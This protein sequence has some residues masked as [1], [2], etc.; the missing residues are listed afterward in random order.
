MPQDAL[1][2]PTSAEQLDRLRNKVAPDE[3]GSSLSLIKQA[4]DR[5]LAQSTGV[6]PLISWLAAYGSADPRN[7]LGAAAQAMTQAVGQQAASKQKLDLDVL[8]LDMA[9]AEKREAIAATA[10]KARLDR[11]AKAQDKTAEYVAV[12]DVD[13]K[14]T[15]IDKNS[16]SG[17]TAIEAI[18]SRGGTVLGIGTQ[19][20][21]RDPLTEKKLQLEI[22]ALENK[23]NELNL[24]E[25]T[26]ESFLNALPE[27]LQSTVKAIAEG[28][29]NPN[30]LS[31][32]NDYRN[33]ILAAVTQYDPNFDARDVLSR[34]RTEVD[35]SVGKPSQSI[36]AAN[37]LLGHLTTLDSK[38]DNLDN[39]QISGY[40]TVANW[41]SKNSGNPQ[42]TSFLVARKAVVNELERVFKGTGG[43]LSEIRDWESAISSAGSTAQLKDAV[44]TAADLMESRTEA[45]SDN[46]ERIMGKR[47]QFI[48]PKGI[49]ALE[50]IKG[51]T[52][53]MVD[54][55][56]TIL[57]VPLSLVESAKKDGLTE[58]EQ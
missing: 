2:A 4:K 50:K 37:T 54:P 12:T 1:S 18:L 29:L 26:G 40:N 23:G 11:D 58:R 33:H 38:I 7:K 43:S 9:A 51:Q 19:K 22:A 6:D 56:G 36:N 34:F 48:S 35:Y 46:Y 20:P 32:R 49:A 24:P 3:E 30:Q 27:Q 14:T 39:K 55:K 15:N 53:E 17:K 45:L 47:K 13:G 52:V 31:A 21:E 42:V 25:G 28:R 10:E 16:P 41:I 8:Q 5:L 57:L 44:K